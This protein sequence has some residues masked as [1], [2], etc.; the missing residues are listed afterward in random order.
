MKDSISLI[1][2]AFLWFSVCSVG[3]AEKP[4]PKHHRN[5]FVLQLVTSVMM[6]HYETKNEIL[7]WSFNWK[8]ME[9]ELNLSLSLKQ[10]MRLKLWWWTRSTLSFAN[11]LPLLLQSKSGYWLPYPGFGHNKTLCAEIARQVAYYLP[12]Y[13]NECPL[14]TSDMV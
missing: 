8:G 2:T 1:I 5:G 7:K 11:A 12:I 10:F 4:Q 13:V 9:M 14:C 6:G 3:F